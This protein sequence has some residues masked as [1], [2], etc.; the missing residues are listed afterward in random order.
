MEDEVGIFDP[1]GLPAYAAYFRDAIVSGASLD[2]DSSTNVNVPDNIYFVLQYSIG[3]SKLEGRIKLHL[4]QGDLPMEV[5]TM[6]K[7][8]YNFDPLRKV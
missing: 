2:G 7:M 5:F 3:S 4:L 1:E 8:A 6:T